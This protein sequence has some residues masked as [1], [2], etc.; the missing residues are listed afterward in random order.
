MSISPD[1]ATIAPG[2][3]VTLRGTVQKARASDL[4][5]SATGGTIAGGG[6]EVVFTADQPGS[7][8]VTATVA[9][10]MDRVTVVVEGVPTYSGDAVELRTDATG[11]AR[12]YSEPLDTSFLIQYQDHAGTPIP[13]AGL[14]YF[15]GDDGYVHVQAG[16]PNDRYAPSF[17]AL[18][19]DQIAGLPTG[20]DL[21]TESFVIL[22]IAGGVFAIGAI[23]AS[24]ISASVATRTMNGTMSSD[25]LDC[26][27]GGCACKR[28]SEIVALYQAQASRREALDGIIAEGASS[29][30]S[31]ILEVT[32][33]SD[34]YGDALEVAGLVA[35][36]ADV[37]SANSFDL[38]F[39]LLDVG[40]RH[41]VLTGLS[42]DTP[43]RVV[44]IGRQE[45]DGG[46][47][48]VRYRW[49]GVV[50]TGEPCDPLTD[51]DRLIGRLDVDFAPY[52]QNA[53]E[54]LTVTA[55]V[56]PAEAGVEITFSAV[57]EKR[58]FTFPSGDEAFVREEWQRVATATTNTSG[59]AQFTI[60]GSLSSFFTDRRTVHYSV[61]AYERGL[62]RIDS[63][64]WT[65]G[66]DGPSSVGIV[67]FE[68]TSHPITAGR[69]TQFAYWAK[70][71]PFQSSA[72]DCLIDFGDGSEIVTGACQLEDGGTSPA[73]SRLVD[74]T[75]REAGIYYATIAAIGSDGSMDEYTRP[76]AVHSPNSPVLD[77]LTITPSEPISDRSF[78]IAWDVDD[79]DGDPLSC[80]IDPD[81]GTLGD[82]VFIEDC[83]DRDRKAV[84]AGDAGWHTGRFRVDDWRLGSAGREFSYLVVPPGSERPIARFSVDRIV[85]NTGESI[86]FDASDSVD[87]DGGSITEYVF[88]SAEAASSTADPV[89]QTTF[90]ASGPQTVCLSV[91]DDEQQS[92]TTCNVFTV[93]APGDTWA[94]INGYTVT[95]PYAGTVDL[96]VSELFSDGSVSTSGQITDP[97]VTG[98]SR[99]SATASTCSDIATAGPITSDLVLDASASLGGTDPGLLRRDAA[100]RFVQRLRSGDR[101]AVASFTTGFTRWQELTSDVSAL[102]RAIDDATRAAGGTAIWNAVSQSAAYLDSDA[103][104]NKAIVLFTD[105]KDSGTGLD[106]AIAAANAA[107]ARVYTVGLGDSSSLDFTTLQELARSTGGLFASAASADQ[108]G[109]AFDGLFN[110]SAGAGCVTVDFDPLAG[111][112]A[113]RT[114]AL[115]TEGIDVDFV[116]N[117]RIDGQPY[118]VPYSVVIPDPST[119]PVQVTVEPDDVQ[120][121]AAAS[122]SF[123]A[124]VQG[125]DDRVIWDATGGS[126]SGSGNTVDYTAPGVG[127]TYTLTATSAAD[128]SAS[129][130][131]TVRV[132]TVGVSLEPAAAS[133]D[134]GESL[135]FTA[136]VTGS[137]DTGVTWST[138]CGTVSGSGSTITYTAP[139]SGGTCSLT[140]VSTVDPSRDATSSITVTETTDPGGSPVW[141]VEPSQLIFRG[142]EGGPAPDSQTF[143][144]HNDGTA[145][146]S[147]TLDSGSIVTTSPTSGTLAA[148]AS[149]TIS[150]DVAACTS[151]STTTSF[152]DVTGG[153]DA[154]RVSIGRECSPEASLT[155]Y[156]QVNIDGLPSGANADI[157]I[158]NNDGVFYVIPF[159]IL[160]PDVPED[161]YQ[162][163]ANPVTYDDT[164]YTPSPTSDTLT[165]QAGQ[166]T[167]V[168]VTYR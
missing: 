152:I 4:E 157:S 21:E 6:A 42:D 125:A 87:P 69:P 88:S 146:S 15:E 89:W 100:L 85:V 123:T 164:T 112:S 74:H 94:A 145:S 113:L 35:E 24:T 97:T 80:S 133:L 129:A 151:D 29:V 65:D 81:V 45:Q 130:S 13:D 142:D 31:G 114:L 2:E 143:D 9:G 84:L 59:E 138:T 12:V 78:D 67:R 96:S 25:I 110:A 149:T 95:D 22:T 39:T 166:T 56:S 41:G 118:S 159:T 98:V 101:A 121:A 50:L 160:V 52:P 14:T 161:T 27:G 58:A 77:A 91:V 36:I 79:V 111:G 30:F 158:T 155:G 108:L 43:Q 127:G 40:D 32:G 70:G 117:F 106:D 141:R 44:F 134:A 140:A 90:E 102:E 126:I 115:S 86:R 19:P 109:I 153:G 66:P 10:A 104:T 147:F 148:G 137:A 3:E 168:D 34:G 60:P 38:E 47:R 17:L 49:R 82:E 99:G 144:L 131:A 76:V 28:P 116:L 83:P 46:E 68:P 103:G 16:G 8:Q 128:A 139:T 23:A 64:E 107:G 135:G 75:Y 163:T 7:Y 72:R 120:L 18:S 63:F 124:Q 48:T 136:S 119:L 11:K 93:T 167:T 51:D 20:G 1:G 57:Q 122:R 71:T 61:A 53:N 92:A 5:W 26:A 33:L 55:R 62:A 150:V 162:L 165:V 73:R 154:A 37:A 132:S 54:D 156:L 105:G